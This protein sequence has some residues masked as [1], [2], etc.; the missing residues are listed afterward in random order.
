MASPPPGLGGARMAQNESIRHFQTRL[1]SEATHIGEARGYNLEEID[2]SP[3]E[4]IAHAR[5]G[6]PEALKVFDERRLSRAGRGSPD[7]RPSMGHDT[8][9]GRRT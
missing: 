6:D 1:D 5:E 3:P 7:Q 2:H 9:K 4:T 8:A